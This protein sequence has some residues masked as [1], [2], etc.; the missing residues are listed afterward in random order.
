MLWGLGLPIGRGTGTIGVGLAPFLF[1]GLVPRVITVQCSPSHLLIPN[2]VCP[3][4][5]VISSHIFGFY[6]NLICSGTVDPL[7]KVQAWPAPRGDARCLALAVLARRPRR[8]RTTFCRTMQNPPA[9]AISLAP[10]PPMELS[11]QLAEGAPEVR[12]PLPPREVVR[13][14]LRTELLR[15]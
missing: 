10:W 13:G 5:A 12:R 9:L 15:F 6:F 8:H 7:G 4:Q 2:D 1:G 3:D 14:L 11:D